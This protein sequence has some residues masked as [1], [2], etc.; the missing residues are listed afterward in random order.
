MPRV[1]PDRTVEVEDHCHEVITMPDVPVLYTPMQVRRVLQLGRTK[2]YQLIADGVIPS[3][4]IGRSRRIP[5]NLLQ[6]FIE[7][8]YEPR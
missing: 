5:A 6:E 2:T 3:I 8:R 1:S 4:S 7:T